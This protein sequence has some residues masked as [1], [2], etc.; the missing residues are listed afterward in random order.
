MSDAHEPFDPDETHRY[1]NPVTLIV[2]QE[3]P[4]RAAAQGLI[5]W[6]GE[7]AE[8][9]VDKANVMRAVL[10]DDWTNTTS[11]KKASTATADGDDKT[12]KEG[13]K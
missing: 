2:Q 11:S 3:T 4:Y 7:E 10:P 8:V 9:E 13:S 1:Y 6:E 12:L 5:F